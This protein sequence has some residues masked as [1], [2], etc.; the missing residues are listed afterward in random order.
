MST[1]QAALEDINW[2]SKR[3]KGLITLSEEIKTYDTMKTQTEEFKTQLSDQKNKFSEVVKKIKDKELYLSELANHHQTAI[4]S[5]NTQADAIIAKAKVDAEEIR[6]K[7]ER[8]AQTLRVSS[9]EDKT[10]MD[11]EISVQIDRLNSLK[12]EV[13]NTSNVLVSLQKQISDLKAR[14]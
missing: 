12:K 3:L 1:V 13:I 7:A 4:V 10:S 14:F 9:Q 6:K 5:H 2:L 8:E 11:R